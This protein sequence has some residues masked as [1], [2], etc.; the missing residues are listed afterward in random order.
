MERK[1]AS[2]LYKICYGTALAGA[3]GS[4]MGVGML[5]ESQNIKLKNY[6]L[7]GSTALI[8]LS[9]TVGLAGL[10]IKEKYFR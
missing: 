2:A 8:S 5:E 1:T 3:I 6:L 10:Y 9:F 7:V 4:I